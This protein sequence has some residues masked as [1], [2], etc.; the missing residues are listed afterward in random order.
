MIWQKA[1]VVSLPHETPVRVRL[2]YG[3]LANRIFS[4]AD[5]LPFTQAS[6]DAI[7]RGGDDWK[8]VAVLSQIL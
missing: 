3:A 4:A 5:L 6:H 7:A 8:K 1:R 2:L